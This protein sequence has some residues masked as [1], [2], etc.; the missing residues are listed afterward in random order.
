MTLTTVP[1]T[2]ALTRCLTRLLEL[3]RQA[4]DLERQ[5]VEAE[6]AMLRQ[7]RAEHEAGRVSQADVD[8][9]FLATRGNVVKGFD[10]RWEEELRIPFRGIATRVAHRIRQQT[11]Y[12][13]NGPSGKTWTGTRVIQPLD[14]APAPGTP[15]AYVLLDERGEAVYVGSTGSFLRRIQWHIRDGKD[16]EGWVAY[17]CA[18]RSGAYEME[19]RLIVAYNV[20]VQ[21]P[22]KA[23][24]EPEDGDE[25]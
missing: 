20:Q 14:P 10:R 12:T 16:F 17:P 22:G 7:L 5:R 18:D 4:E 15:V 13:P 11:R 8:D 2:A 25:Q 9:I 24:R 3:R 6:L 21:R 1:P 19:D 23:Y